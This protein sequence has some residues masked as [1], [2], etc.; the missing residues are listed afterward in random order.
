MSTM[1]DTLLQLPLFQ[2]LCREDFSKILE[3][4]KLHFTKY[5]AGESILK[6]GTAC[7]QLIFLLKGEVSSMTTSQDGA[8]T[9]IEHAEAPYVIEP[10]ALLGMNINYASSYIARTEVNAIIINKHFVLNA[11]LNYDVFRL[12]YMN[13]ISNRAQTLHARLWDQVPQDL[14]DKTARFILVH[15]EKLR[16]EK[17]VKVKMDDLARYLDDTRLNVS[18]MLNS[19]QEEGLLML[20]R[21]EIVIK[22]A[23]LFIDWN[24]ERKLREKRGM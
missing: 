1:Y 7:D 2:G 12:N 22:D 9:I 24:N 15:T 11:L 4:V 3:K 13:F 5:K 20:H 10:H 8:F 18:K 23:Q 19:L 17:I 16:G 21:K 14:I 6:S